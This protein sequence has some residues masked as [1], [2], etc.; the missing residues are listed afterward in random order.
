MTVQMPQDT[1]NSEVYIKT[2]RGHSAVNMDPWTPSTWR[3]PWNKH[4]TPNKVTKD[5]LSSFTQQK[6]HR[7]I[8]LYRTAGRQGGSKRSNWSPRPTEDHN[9]RAFGLISG[10]CTSPSSRQQKLNKVRKEETSPYPRKRAWEATPF[11]PHGAPLVISLDEEEEQDKTS[12]TSPQDH[13]K[14]HPVVYE[15]QPKSPVYP[16][17]S[18]SSEE[19]DFS[20]ISDLVT[21]AE[22]MSPAPGHLN[23]SGYE[24]QGTVPTDVNA[25]Q[26]SF[27]DKDKQE[28][29]AQAL[30]DDLSKAPWQKESAKGP[31]EDLEKITKTVKLS[32]DGFWHDR[33]QDIITG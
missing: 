12:P 10:P 20:C 16:P 7:G 30:E 18:D 13:E 17:P 6:T 8:S 24:T 25:D 14:G 1:V 31:L 26:D 23:D 19:E 27:Q 28:A 29:L 4:H 3:K 21:P 15:Y 22:E 11:N 32:Y 2:P 9:P 5:K 33:D